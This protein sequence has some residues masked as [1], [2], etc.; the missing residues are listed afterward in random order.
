MIR[1]AKLWCF[2]L[3]FSHHSGG[4]MTADIEKATQDIVAAA[5]Y[6]NRLAGDISRDVTARFGK[7]I[8]PGGKLPRTRE[9]C[10][11]LEFV[12]LFIGIPGG[13]DGPGVFQ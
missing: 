5:N 1:T 9:D 10:L 3:R 4:V 11:Q 8:Q 7:L 6:D 2:A 12:K 13:R